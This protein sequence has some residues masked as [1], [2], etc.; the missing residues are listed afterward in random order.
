[1]VLPMH[2][3]TERNIPTSGE[4]EG[5]TWKLVSVATTV[6]PRLI[7]MDDA[8]LS[9]NIT[10]RELRDRIDA[11]DLRSV[12]IGRRRLVPLTEIDAYVAR[13]LEGPSTKRVAA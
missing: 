13:L 9:L 11:G 10:T 1:M 5:V 4:T 2:G 7:S 8:A 3:D 6:D 12:Y